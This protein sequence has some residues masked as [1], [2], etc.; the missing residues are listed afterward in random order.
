MRWKRRDVAIADRCS[1][2]NFILTGE[3]ESEFIEG[4][5]VFKYLGRLLDRSDNNW[6]EVLQNI[7][8]AIQVWGRLG[9]LLLR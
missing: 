9:E 3:E 7:R 5:E 1:E 6:P 4:V 8:K 2:A